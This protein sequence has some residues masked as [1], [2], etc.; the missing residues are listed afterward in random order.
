MYQII[1]YCY[2][3]LAIIS[4]ASSCLSDVNLVAGTT[5]DDVYHVVACTGVFGID[6]DMSPRSVDQPT[7]PLVLT[8]H[9]MNAV[10]KTIMTRNFHLL[11]DDLDTG[12]IYR[13]LRVLCAYRRDNN[14]RDSLVR[15]HLNETTASVE[16]RGTF[17]CGRTRCNTCAH[18]NASTTINS[19]VAYS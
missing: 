9:P 11:R 4:Q 8:Y 14:L 10:V 17:P 12:D 1:E 16:D 15:S 19:K 5:F 3:R 7:I 18:T 13:P 6:V 2:N